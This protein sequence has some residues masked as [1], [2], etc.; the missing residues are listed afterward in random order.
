MDGL[1]AQ[2]RQRSLVLAVVTAI[3]LPAARGGSG[4]GDCPP[5]TGPVLRLI[6]ASFLTVGDGEHRA[7]VLR[8]RVRL[9][10]AGLGTDL[11]VVTQTDMRD[12]GVSSCAGNQKRQPCSP[13]LT[14]TDKGVRSPFFARMGLIVQRDARRWSVDQGSHPLSSGYQ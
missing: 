1:A 14:L 2:S 10:A 6:S 5:M 8:R 3:S 7:L 12:Q 9:D 11:L 4:A 13:A